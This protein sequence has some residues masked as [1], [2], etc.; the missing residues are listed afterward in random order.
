M[1]EL[2]LGA[3]A[4]G[5]GTPGAIVALAQCGDYIKKK[6]DSFKNAP[7]LV[8]EIGRF[9]YDLNQGKIKINIELAEWAYS[10]EDVD[11]STKDAIEELINKLRQLLQEVDHTLSKLFDKNGQTRR[12]YFTLLGERKTQQVVKSLRNWQHDFFN[13]ISLIEMR[14][15]VVPQDLELSWKKY[16][17]KNCSNFPAMTK[18]S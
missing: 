18:F 15:R 3:V 13:I 1:A 11:Q 6:V 4:F 12:M 10:L 17:P 8:Q 7:A 2:I 16:R 9:G 5:I 14:R